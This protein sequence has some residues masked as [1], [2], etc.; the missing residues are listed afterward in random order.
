MVSWG[1]LGQ[2][3]SNLCMVVE[4]EA[5]ENNRPAGANGIFV[6]QTLRDKRNRKVIF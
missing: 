4:F 6:A 2:K 1:C 3:C 5:V